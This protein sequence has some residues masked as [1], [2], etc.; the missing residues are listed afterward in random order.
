MVFL[1]WLVGLII[2]GL[3]VIGIYMLENGVYVLYFWYKVIGF[4]VFFVVLVC[5][6]WCMKNG[7]FSVVVNYK[8]IEYKLVLVVY[9]V[10]IIVMFLMLI[11][12]LMVLVLGG[13]GLLVF[14]LEVFVLNYSV[15]DFEKM[16]LINYEFFKVGGVIYF[17]FGYIVIVVFLLY[18]V[19]VFKYYFVDKDGI[20]KCML[21][22]IIGE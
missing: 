10:L 9:W 14:G 3:F 8:L 6:V 22:K 17:Y 20:L 15:E 13:Y 12:G 16:L 5:V 4:F 11:L 18:I 2:I 19:G 7:W 21:G 1:Y